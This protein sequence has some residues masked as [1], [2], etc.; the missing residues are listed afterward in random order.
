M[1]E[2][3]FKIL[4][5]DLNNIDSLMHELCATSDCDKTLLCNTQYVTTGDV[6]SIRN[7][8]SG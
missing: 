4:P 8:L 2:E 5:H 3:V 6:C 7:G 1:D